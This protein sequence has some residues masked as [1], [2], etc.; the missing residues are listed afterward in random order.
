MVTDKDIRVEDKSI[1]WIINHTIAQ[2]RN[3]YGLNCYTVDRNNSVRLIDKYKCSNDESFF[4]NLDGVRKRYYGGE[5]NWVLMDFS[6]D[7]ICLDNQETTF[8]G[9]EVLNKVK[10]ENVINNVVD[11]YFDGVCYNCPD[12]MEVKYVSKF[13]DFIFSRFIDK[14]GDKKHNYFVDLINEISY[15]KLEKFHD[16]ILNKVTIDYAKVLYG[17]K[18]S[19]KARI[20]GEKLIGKVDTDFHLLFFVDEGVFNVYV[21][22]FAKR[23]VDGDLDVGDFVYNTPDEYSSNLNLLRD[24]ISYLQEEKW[25]RNSPERSYACLNSGRGSYY[26]HKDVILESVCQDQKLIC[27]ALI[28]DV[29]VRRISDDEI[30]KLINGINKDFDLKRLVSKVDEE[31]LNIFAKDIAKHYVDNGLKM[32]VGFKLLNRDK[33]NILQTAYV[34]AR[35]AYGQGGLSIAKG[36]E[37]G[38][39]LDDKVGGLT[40]AD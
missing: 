7:L 3:R 25:F 19:D 8:R 1:E 26:V 27:D 34:V 33:W 29:L 5:I 38:L 23:F 22:N 11:T 39:S 15:T 32:D 13:D 6:L 17:I 12:I 16:K 14:M 24:R 10:F 31:P 4:N 2:N 21:D 35:D 9:I 20:V 28:D 18:D 37:G 40:K 30:K 36:D